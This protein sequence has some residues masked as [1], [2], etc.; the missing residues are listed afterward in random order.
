[1]IQ[2]SIRRYEEEVLCDVVPMHVG[3][4][5]LGHP[6]QYDRRVMPDGFLNRYSFEFKGKPIVLV[7]MSPK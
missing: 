7:L 4:I 3:H 2:F 5:L 6:W 1:M